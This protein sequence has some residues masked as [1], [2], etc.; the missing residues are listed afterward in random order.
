M[1]KINELISEGIR[2]GFCE[3]NSKMTNRICYGYEQNDYG[4]LV[5]NDQKAK[6]V[7]RI[8]DFIFR[9]IV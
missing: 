3:G 2:K 4:K 7:K 6:I 1:D 9:D 5:I 8:F